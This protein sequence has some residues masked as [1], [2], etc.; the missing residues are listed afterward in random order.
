[1]KL[2][3]SK[4]LLFVLPLNILVTLSSY[5]HNKNKTYMITNHTATTTS[6]VLSECDTLSSIYDNDRDIKSVK[7]NFDRQT[8]QRLREYDERMK[9]KRQKRKEER[10][11]NIEQ[12]IEKDKMDK[13]LADKIEKGCLKCG[14][15]LGGVAASVGLIGGLTVNELKKAALLSATQDATAEGL[16]AGAAARIKAGIDSVISGIKTEFDILTLGNQSLESFINPNTYTDVKNITQAVYNQY[17]GTCIYS[18]GGSGAHK[19]ICTLM[20]KKTAAARNIPGMTRG[21]AVSENVVIQKTVETIVS[22]A[23]TVAGEAAERA[24]KEAI[25]A[26]TDAVDSTYAICQ[27]AIIA[28]VVALLIIVLVMIIIYLVLRYRRKKKMIKKAQYTK[29]LNQ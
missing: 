25:K 7:E 6:R 13:S 2:R 14:C 22:K 18:T 23:E 28:S 16:T 5:A 3:Y 20:E 17:E 27:N 11:K 19:S 24:T 21:N 10:D 29:L 1:M 26:S 4:I 15:G 9:D 8:S 12:I